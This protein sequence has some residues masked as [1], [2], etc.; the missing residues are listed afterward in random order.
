MTKHSST[1][2]GFECAC[3][4]NEGVLVSDPEKKGMLALASPDAPDRWEQSILALPIPKD[5]EQVPLHPP[6]ATPFFAKK[7]DDA[8][9]DAPVADDVEPVDEVEQVDAED[10]TAQDDEA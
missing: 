9:G 5:A 6:K 7:K 4:K 10:D 1:N 2:S 8:A 3:L